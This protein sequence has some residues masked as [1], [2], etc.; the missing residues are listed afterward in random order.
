MTPGETPRLCSPA[1]CVPWARRHASRWHVLGVVGWHHACLCR[2]H[3]ATA[4]DQAGG[5]C[6]PQ[7]VAPAVQRSSMLNKFSMRLRVFCPCPFLCPALPC[8]VQRLMFDG[9]RCAA[10]DDECFSVDFR[11]AWL[12]GRA[13]GR[14]IQRMTS[15]PLST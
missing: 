14:G 3:L 13:G 10:E 7:Q 12:G 11:L 8:P 4:W 2:P 1:S 6:N 9:A 5:G 15:A